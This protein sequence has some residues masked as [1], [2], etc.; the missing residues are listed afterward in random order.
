MNEGSRQI[1]SL[2]EHEASLMKI[3]CQEEV[4]NTCLEKKRLDCP[5]I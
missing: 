1:D 3:T 5:F 2:L 4:Y